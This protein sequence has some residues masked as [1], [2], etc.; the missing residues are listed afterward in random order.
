MN[1]SKPFLRQLLKAQTILLLKCLELLLIFCNQFKNDIS[2][3]LTLL[4]PI[5]AQARA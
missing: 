5:N 3:T 4:H 1:C 2:G